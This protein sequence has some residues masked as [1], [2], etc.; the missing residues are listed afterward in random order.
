MKILSLI[1]LFFFNISLAST[2]VE[3]NT[4]LGISTI[5][6][7][8]AK[9][10][11]P[12]KIIN[13]VKETTADYENKMKSVHINELNSEVQTNQPAEQIPPTSQ[14]QLTQPI[15]QT[16][17]VKPSD[18]N[19]NPGTLKRKIVFPEGLGEEERKK[20]LETMSEE[21]LES[22]FKDEKIKSKRTSIDYSRNIN[23]F[24]CSR[25]NCS[26]GTNCK[27][28]VLVNIKSVYF[29]FASKRSSYV[30]CLDRAGN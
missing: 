28:P 18:E 5:T 13:K 14:H 9:M 17:Q 27:V 19:Q 2:L 24:D 10:S 29:D 25:K 7:G 12:K 11:N 8:G 20:L 30:S 3:T 15:Q 21:E 16:S 26:A 4:A 22:Y 6:S 1:P 23:I